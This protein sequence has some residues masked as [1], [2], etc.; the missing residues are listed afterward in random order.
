MSKMRPGDFYKLKGIWNFRDNETKNQR[1]LFWQKLNNGN[2]SKVLKLYQIQPDEKRPLTQRNLLLKSQGH[3]VSLLDPWCLPDCCPV[4]DVY[5]CE[6]WGNTLLWVWGIFS[7]CCAS[8]HFALLHF[9][10]H[11]FPLDTLAQGELEII[12][13]ARRYCLFLSIFHWF[14][15]ILFCFQ[16]PDRRVMDS[17]EIIR[18]DGEQC[19]HWQAV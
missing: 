16:I 3:I 6:S 1:Y 12:R 11:D 19:H 18:G 7:Y 15:F 13:K 8:L 10:V 5:R 2:G 4:C 9:C 17:A 14:I